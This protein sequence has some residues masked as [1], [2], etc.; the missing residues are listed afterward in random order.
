MTEL[1]RELGSFSC[2]MLVAGNMI[3]I[4]IFVTAGRIAAVLPH[5][6]MILIAWILGGLLSLAG[7]LSYAELGTRFPRAGGTY[8]YLREAF[9]PLTGFLSGFSC[10]VI[11]IPGASAFLAIGFTRYAG[12]TDPQLAKGIAVFLIILFSI[13]NYW[14]VKWGAGLQNSF[15]ILKLL[16]IFA[17]IFA[18]FLSGNGSLQ[19]FFSVGE[20]SHSYLGALPLAMIPIL[21]TYSGWDA[22]IYV[23]G[24]IKHPSRTIPFSLFSGTL[25]VTFIYLGLA[26]LYIYAIPVTSPEHKTKIVTAASSIFFGERIGKIVG[27]LVALS[28]LGC[29][30]A[31]ILTGPRVVYA[32]A[33]DGLLP[34]KM[35]HIHELFASPSYAIFFQ[36]V[37]ASLLVVTGTFD[38]LLDF[39]TVPAIFFQTLTVIGLFVLRKRNHADPAAQV[40]STLGYPIVPAL[41][42]LAQA[43]IILSTIIKTPKDSLWGLL[44]VTL[45]LPLYFYWNRQTKF[46][47]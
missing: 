30:S 15:M 46:S 36:G 27:G 31:A 47:S 6:Q 17:L 13:V 39:A 25:I 18:G 2:T 44:M 21:Y 12:I 22:S 40:Y 1:K 26:A 5:P 11:T 7:A 8:I 33:K 24:E 10:S 35:A 34:S 29:L 4:G 9:G 41:F 32:M 14:G 42:V 45:G 19:N 3:G 37:V 23:A 20:I 28:I 38:Q 43:W 16:L